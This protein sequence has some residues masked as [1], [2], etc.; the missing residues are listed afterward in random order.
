[1]KTAFT[2]VFLLFSVGLFAQNNS[3]ELTD[4]QFKNT[5]L[6]HKELV[7]IPNLPENK[8][9][10]LENINWVAMQYQ[11]LDFKTSPLRIDHAAFTLRRKNL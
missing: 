8:E 6:M 10:M 4:Q 2:F 9:K 3:G 7:S 11:A 1:M 5:L